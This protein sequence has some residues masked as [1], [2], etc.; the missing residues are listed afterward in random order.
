MDISLL[1]LLTGLY[2]FVPSRS[3]WLF[4]I[5]IYFK[6]WTYLHE[7]YNLNC[8]TGFWQWCITFQIT[9]FFHHL[10]WNIIHH[11]LR[12][13]SVPVWSLKLPKQLSLHNDYILTLMMEN[14]Q[15]VY[16]SSNIIHLQQHTCTQQ[17]WLYPVRNVLCIHSVQN[18]A[19]FCHV[20]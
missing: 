9:D 2:L 6:M 17:F 19:Y 14:V 7:Q 15:A 10:C 1:S 5:T 8:S 20:T 4:K 16:R 3:I 11:V 18:V 13:G 12:I